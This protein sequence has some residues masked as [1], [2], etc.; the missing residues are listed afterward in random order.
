MVD[1]LA[2][3]NNGLMRLLLRIARFRLSAARVQPLPQRGKCASCDR[4]SVF[5]LATNR[6]LMRRMAAWPYHD[7]V[8]DALATRENYFCIWC[9]RNLRMR[10]VASVAEAAI[11]QADVYEPAG[12]GVFSAQTRRRARS[13][14]DSEYLDGA[15]PG[16]LIRGRRHE[17]LMGLTFPDET[18]DVVITSE[19]F[20][21]VADP[22]RAFAEIRRVLRA[23]GRHIFS[24]PLVPGALT[25][26]RRGAPPVYHADPLRRQGSVVHT[27][28]GDDLP[29]LLAPLGFRTIVHTFPPASPMAHVLESVAV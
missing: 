6:S 28:F 22:W 17:D 24:V 10:L 15:R 3:A 13:Y 1:R 27:D 2:L 21:H 8:L 19:V 16:Q 20:E 11:E 23:G 5:I 25:A 26:S 18:F 29:E 7:A 4:P 14:V 9:G 12:F